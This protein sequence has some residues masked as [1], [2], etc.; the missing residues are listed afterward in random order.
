MAKIIQQQA[1]SIIRYLKLQITKYLSR[2]YLHKLF[3]LVYP[4]G[5]GI[6]FAIG[7]NRILDQTKRFGECLLYFKFCVL[8]F[9]AILFWVF[10]FFWIISLYRLLIREEKVT[11]EK[12]LQT[13]HAIHNVPN[14][15]IFTF[16]PRYFAAVYKLYRSFRKSRSISKKGASDNHIEE[17]LIIIKEILTIISTMASMFAHNYKIER[18]Q[19]II[20]NHPFYISNV[21]LLINT[22][23]IPDE[24]KIK[25]DLKSKIP[26]KTARSHDITDKNYNLGIL[27]LPKELWEDSDEKGLNKF[28]IE[29]VLPVY[30]P[31]IG[32]PCLPGAPTAAI[33]G[34]S[35]LSDTRDI[36]KDGDFSNIQKE[37]IK[38]YFSNLENGV[39]MRSFASFRIGDEDNP[40]GI[41]NINCTVPYLLGKNPEYYPS[42]YAFLA[43]I[44]RLLEPMIEVYARDC[45][46]KLFSKQF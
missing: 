35:I 23:D 26:Y 4:V 46:T 9:D 45:I 11:D 5:A 21:M 10:A 42:F 43:P 25:T 37:E 17:T 34:S 1:N 28:K 22:A 32:I 19:E 8:G 14:K 33:E 29:I 40:V 20:R 24:E 6:W 39:K 16:Y 3:T 27:Y 18:N 36:T 7:Q 41:I 2:K 15:N 44:L 38:N 12:F 31:E 13:L 30:S